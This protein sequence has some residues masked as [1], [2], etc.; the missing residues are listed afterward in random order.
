MTPAEERTRTSPEKDATPGAISDQNREEQPSEFRNDESRPEPRT[1]DKRN[2]E[3]SE[4]SEG[5][6][7]G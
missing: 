4:R 1:D 6:H 2:G 7:G 3:D 5:A